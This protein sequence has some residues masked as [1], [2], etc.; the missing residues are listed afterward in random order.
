VAHHGEIA[1]DLEERIDLLE[2][3]IELGHLGGVVDD[4]VPERGDAGGIG[5]RDHFLES[6]QPII[7]DESSRSRLK[8]RR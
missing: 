3:F 4:G 5:E 1:V 2:R 8:R 7:G 6:A